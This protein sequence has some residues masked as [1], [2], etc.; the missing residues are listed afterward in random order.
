MPKPVPPTV[1]AELTYEVQH[2]DTLTAGDPS[3][4][5][6]LSTARLIAWLEQACFNALAPYHEPGEITVGTAVNVLHYAPSLTGAAI[7]TEATLA[8]VEKGRYYVMRVRATNAGREIARGVVYRGFIAV[9]EFMSKT[10]VRG[11]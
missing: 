3:L 2:A 7:R 8:R 5:P 11:Q 1:S 4:P 10:K 9:S 6:V